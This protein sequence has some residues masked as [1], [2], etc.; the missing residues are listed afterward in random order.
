MDGSVCLNR[1]ELVNLV[2]GSLSQAD[3]GSKG[4][5]L[6]LVAMCLSAPGT[7]ID[8]GLP[9]D[10]P[11]NRT[12]VIQQGCSRDV[13]LPESRMGAFPRSTLSKEKNISALIGDGAGVNCDGVQSGCTHTKSYPQGEANQTFCLGIP[14]QPSFDVDDFSILF[15]PQAL[16]ITIVWS[17][18]KEVAVGCPSKNTVDVLEDKTV[19]FFQEGRCQHIFRAFACD[20]NERRL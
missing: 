12:V 2:V 5:S 19:F 1:A 10:Y 9:V 6:V 7:S 16:G 17:R 11:Q 20:S 3:A 8:P 15:S 4:V 13:L 18:L 14:F